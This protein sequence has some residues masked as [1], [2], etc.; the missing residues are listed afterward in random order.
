M[1]IGPCTRQ[2]G[3][4]WKAWGLWEARIHFVEYTYEVLFWVYP[5]FQMFT[6]FGIDSDIWELGITTVFK[7]TVFTD[8]FTIN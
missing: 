5:P 3:S 7:N 2:A 1:L 4:T 6:S 8:Y